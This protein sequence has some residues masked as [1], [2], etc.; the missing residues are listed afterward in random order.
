[1]LRYYLQRILWFPVSW[2][3][4]SLVAFGLSKIAP[5]DPVAYRLQDGSLGQERSSAPAEYE[6]EYRVLAQRMGLDKPTFYF[7]ILP[8]AYP[9]TL[10]RIVQPNRR[11]AVRSWL[12]YG[13]KEE[14]VSVFYRRLLVLHQA[15]PKV[16]EAG[17]EMAS[18]KNDLDGF[19]E[20]KDPRAITHQ[21]DAWQSQSGRLPAPLQ[22]E[23]AW[24]YQAWDSLRGG[25]SLYGLYVP[26]IRWHGLDNQFHPWLTGLFSGNMGISYLDGR[27]VREKI[28]EALPWTLI[29]NGAALFLALLISIPAGCW[30]GWRRGEWPDTFLSVLFF[31][32]Y[33]LPT[34]WLGTLLLMLFTTPDY[35]M[36]GFPALGPV[37]LRAAGE[38]FGATVYRL[39]SH[40]FLPVVCLAL[41]A[42]AFLS[43]QV[44]NSLAEVLG[45]DYIL[46][47]RARG[48]PASSLRWK[49]AGRNAL[50]PL[51]TLLAGLFPALLAGSLVV[52]VIFNLYG[53]GMLAV[54]SIFARDWQTLLG[55]VQLSALLT[56]LGLLIA[57]LLYP[58]ADPRI[59][60]GDQNLPSTFFLFTLVSLSFPLLLVS[61]IILEIGFGRDG[62]DLFWLFA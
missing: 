12:R 21:L 4:I 31:L 45:K 62:L 14:A 46:A 27:P 19:L 36:Q 26:T 41:G 20:E 39:S 11:A 33:A 55:I 47:A 3:L 50:F 48:L 43:R 54:E 15:S 42:L 9:D 5:G 44:R 16:S 59:V 52:E 8:L 23:V 10:H 58:L 32:A 1:M 56:I 53:M 29:L 25:R 22:R 51:I 35:H 2:F 30:M 38:S 40:F 61:L 17:E 13:A 7:S 49:H 24:L 6:Q 34:F 37:Y 57:D 28:G 18:W 60:L